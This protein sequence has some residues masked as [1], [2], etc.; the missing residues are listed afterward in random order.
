MS[1]SKLQASASEDGFLL[2][3]DDL[4]KIV[5]LLLWMGQAF[6]SNIHIDDIH[7]A[8][9]EVIIKHSDVATGGALDLLHTTSVAKLSQ[10]IDIM[11][12]NRDGSQK[13]PNDTL[14]FMRRCAK[15]RDEI[16]PTW[17]DNATERVELDGNSV[18][19][20]YQRFGRMLLANDLLPDQKQ[21]KRY[22]LRNN[23]DG[24]THLS[25]VQRSF[26]D[27]MLRKFLGDK[28]VAFL[29]W[30]HGIPSVADNSVVYPRRV[31][32]MGS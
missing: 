20:C 8:A 22:R 3:D 11:T 12:T 2:G 15:I 19:V 5:A 30:Q 18:S 17:G 32:S 7:H 13:D 29:I 4:E 26:T 1:T 6:Q 25:S 23:F 21:D 31:Y 10:L 28:R 16:R 24:D 14:A 27:N 9:L